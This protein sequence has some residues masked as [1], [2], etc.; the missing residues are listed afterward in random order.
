MPTWAGPYEGDEPYAF[1]S[2]LHS[3]LPRVAPI[4]HHL[5]QTGLR[6]WSD[7]G[8]AGGRR[9]TTVLAEGIEKCRL[10]LCFLS[11][12]AVASQWVRKEVEFAVVRKRR[13]LP[14]MLEPVDFRGFLGLLLVRIQSLDA[15]R[16][17]FLKMLE[18]AV[19]HWMSSPADEPPHDVAGSEPGVPA[20]SGDSA[21]GPAPDVAHREQD[22]EGIDLE[23]LA[24]ARHEEYC[25]QP[26]SEGFTRETYPWL[27]PYSELPEDYREAYRA[28]VRSALTSLH[29]L[30]YSFQPARND[31][32][33][34]GLD[35]H[36]VEELA[37]AEHKRWWRA[38]LAQGWMYGPVKDV[39][40][41][42]HPCM[43]P[44]EQL[45]DDM[46][47]RDRESARG[48]PALLRRAGYELAEGNG[49]RGR[50]PAVTGDSRAGDSAG[51]AGLRHVRVNE[52][53]YHEYECE[54]DGSV[55]VLI[56]E[57]EFEMGSGP[58]DA[59]AGDDEKPRHRVKLSAYLMGKVPVTNGQYRQFVEATGHRAPGSYGEAFAGEKQPVVGVS[60][61]DAVAYCEW[62]GLRLPAEAQW[63]RA[64]SG[65]DGRKYPWG[66]EA[67]DETR[68]NHERNVGHPTP[69]GQ[70]PAGVS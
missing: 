35:A 49:P 66:N 39:I 51:P 37:V 67:P 48:L 36:E 68:A 38:K 65:T 44:W 10:V 3:D 6:L 20:R 40:E 45:P 34:A 33:G 59:E 47:E 52:Q 14:I 18:G 69:V 50:S 25:Q 31:G 16:P 70:Y 27:V 53:G 23:R 17:D 28:G 7:A 29:A 54:K 55:L 57:G 21:Q 58:E 19:S 2:Y 12:G 42:R 41:K 62:A 63:E 9:W 8:P 56:P 26:R 5:A 1:A 61:D 4:L 32:H 30:G 46:K 24:E 60:W 15:T 11:R 64:A 13:L 22:L 43:V